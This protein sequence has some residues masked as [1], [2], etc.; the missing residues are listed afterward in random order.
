M[1]NLALA[2]ELRRWRRAGRTARLWWRDDDAAGSATTLERLLLDRLVAVARK[3]GTPVT[4]AVVP[5][6]ELSGLAVRLAE[7]PA[8]VSVAQHGTDH[9]NRRAGAAA[10]ELPHDWTAAQVREALNHGWA[11][12]ATLPRAIKVFMP[13]WNDL[14]PALAAVLAE[15]GYQALSASGG[16]GE[17]AGSGLPRLDGHLDLMRWR[18]G[19]RFRGRGRFAANL[20]AELRRRRRARRWDAPIGLLTHHLAHDA[21]AW[22]FLAEFLAWTRAR[23]EFA[24]TSLQELL[25]GAGQAGETTGRTEQGARSLAHAA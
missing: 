15:E 4:L 23:P 5:S 16:L 12:M 20:T 8:L 3:A 6:G 25:S 9:Q 17:A 2:L 11:R 22:S 24:W 10:G 21:A 18:G 13:P 1:R 19:V 14:H 7:A